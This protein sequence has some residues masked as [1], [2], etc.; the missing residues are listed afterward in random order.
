MSSNC[1]S[2]STWYCKASSIWRLDDHVQS[3]TGGLNAR[4]KVAGLMNRRQL[5]DADAAGIGLFVWAWPDGPSVFTE[6]LATLARMGFHRQPALQPA[7]P[8]SHR[9]RALAHVLV[10]PRLPFASDGAGAA[11]SITSARQTLASQRP[12]LGGRLEVPDFQGAGSG[13]QG[14]VQDR[15]HGAHHPHSG[16]GA[17]AAGRPTDPPCQR[18]LLETL[19]S[20]GYSPWATKYPSAWRAR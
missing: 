20:A 14:A 8:N 17:G 4:S 18:R 5:S 12:L 2:P 1:R 3:T 16:V 13:T 9:S 11:P 19:A 6:R 10:Q 15:P 7:H